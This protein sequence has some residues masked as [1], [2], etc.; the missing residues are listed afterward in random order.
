MNY[1]ISE[2]GGY[3]PSG[4]DNSTSDEL[5]NMKSEQD[6]VIVVSKTKTYFFGLL[7]LLL[8]WWAFWGRK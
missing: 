5:Q 1:P 2:N 3:K 7:V 8:L 6:G 4:N